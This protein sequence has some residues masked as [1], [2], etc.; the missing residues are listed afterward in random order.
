MSNRRS[1]PAGTRYRDSIAIISTRGPSVVSS[2]LLAPQS[3]LRRA[4]LP[5]RNPCAGLYSDGPESDMDD[6]GARSGQSGA[7][8]DLS[9][10]L[11]TYISGGRDITSVRDGLIKNPE[12][13]CLVEFY[14]DSGRQPCI[15]TLRE[16]GFVWN[17]EIFLNRWSSQY[18]SVA[19]RNPF[20]QKMSNSIAEESLGD[21]ELMAIDNI[22]VHEIFPED[23]PRLF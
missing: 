15:M 20:M 7:D 11:V 17:Q 1:T 4:S 18:E 10:L 2:S 5:A 14:S 13:R 12:A 3:R 9:S 6:I 19:R 23:C 16:D 21:G 8:S 22:N